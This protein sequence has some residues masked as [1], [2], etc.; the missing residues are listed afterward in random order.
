MLVSL[1]FPFFNFFRAVA[2]AA[3]SSCLCICLACFHVVSQ[4]SWGDVQIGD[5]AILQWTSFGADLHDHCLVSKGSPLLPPLVW[6]AWP[7]LPSLC[8]PCLACNWD[9]LTW[10]LCTHCSRGFLQRRGHVNSFA[11]D[12]KGTSLHSCSWSYWC[13]RFILHLI[14]NSA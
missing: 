5:V 10:R 3:L 13:V 6:S 12:K 1:Y 9:S 11:N 14:V 2:G 8:V 4:V 7:L